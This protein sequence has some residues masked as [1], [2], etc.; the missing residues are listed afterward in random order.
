MLERQE[1]G[2]SFSDEAVEAVTRALHPGLFE[3]DSLLHPMLANSARWQKR[4][5]VRA[6]LEAA[7]PLL[8][9]SRQQVERTLRE[10]LQNS[11]FTSIQ[12]EPVR[13]QM[14]DTWVDVLA[15]TV[16]SL[17]ASTTSTQGETQS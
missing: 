1:S 7:A 14:I 6:A 3:E 16:M 9:P 13:T 11:N 5:E 10:R 4:H 8:F 15:G 12:H 2:R 17:L